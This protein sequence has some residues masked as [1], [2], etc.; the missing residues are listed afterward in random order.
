MVVGHDHMPYEGQM[1]GF[2]VKPTSHEN[3][4]N[5]AGSSKVYTTNMI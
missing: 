5:C 2:M 3:E 4:P 1:K